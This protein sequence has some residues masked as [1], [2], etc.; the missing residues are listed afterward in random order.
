MLRNY[1]FVVLISNNDEIASVCDAIPE[2]SVG[3]SPVSDGV[4]V[5]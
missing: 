1:D 2:A 3:E 4:P 5:L